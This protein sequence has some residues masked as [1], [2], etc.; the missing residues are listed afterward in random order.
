MQ[1]SNTLKQWLSGP[2]QTISMYVCLQSTLNPCEISN[3]V[4][5]FPAG[6]VLWMIPPEEATEDNLS[7]T[8]VSLAATP[9]A[10]PRPS[11]EEVRRSL[12]LL[13]TCCTYCCLASR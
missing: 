13:Y 9:V 6:R 11:L 8:D 1:T 5:V 12:A 7:S 3:Q 2:E 4:S 10:S